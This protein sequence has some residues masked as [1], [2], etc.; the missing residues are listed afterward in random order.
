MRKIESIAKL[1]ETAIKPKITRVVAYA[2][3]S[4]DMEEWARID[5]RQV[6]GIFIKIVNKIMRKYSQI[7]SVSQ[8]VEK[9]LGIDADIIINDAYSM[10]M[11]YCRS[12]LL[13]IS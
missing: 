12:P 7:L 1:H 3:V 5:L 6:P 11:P 13:R 10:D 2:R 8:E 9:E 4:T